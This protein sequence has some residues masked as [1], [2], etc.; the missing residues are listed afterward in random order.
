MTGSQYLVKS[1]HF[2]C[3]HRIMKERGEMEETRNFM[4]ELRASGCGARALSATSKYS[5]SF[6]CG[7]ST[8]SPGFTDGFKGSNV[9]EF[10]MGLVAGEVYVTIFECA[11]YYRL[12][13]KNALD[14]R[15]RE[16]L[17]KLTMLPSVDKILPSRLSSLRACHSALLQHTM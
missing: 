8:E 12:C 6:L 9:P 13:W 1:G 11:L 3:F 10:A 4:N 7:K 16:G 5:G 15:V 17:A 14:D 2:L